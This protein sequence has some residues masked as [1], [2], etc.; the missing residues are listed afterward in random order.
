MVVGNKREDRRI[1]R[2]RQL[3][4]KGFV[5]AMR[6]KGFA[7]MSIQ[8]ITDRANVNRGT[9]YIHFS[10]KYTL[11]DEIVRDN[12]GQ[13][14]ANL[15][16]PEPRWDRRN[17]QLFILTVFN[18]FESKYQ[19]RKPSTRFPA[20][21]LEQAIHEEITNYLIRWIRPAG[22]IE[23]SEHMRWEMRARVISWA[24]FGAAINWSQETLKISVDQMA[25]AVLSVIMDGTAP[26]D[27]VPD[28]LL[29]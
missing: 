5:E 15:L 16:P 25:D 24:I 1:Q 19:H 7:A 27:S 18:C 10:D 3:L 8:D 23:S 2:T 12:F 14:L 26:A 20:A 13:L 29:E 21:I 11:L 6:E 17:L 4:R 28:G 22:V 9:F